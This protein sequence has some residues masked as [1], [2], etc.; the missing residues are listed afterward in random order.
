MPKWSREIHK[1]MKTIEYNKLIRDKIPE[2]IEKQG[3]TCV[4]SR[5]NDE[6]YAQ[7]LAEKLTE[8]MQE[9]L[10]EFDAEKDEEAVKELADLVEVVYAILDL[11]GVDK[12]DFEKIRQAKTLQ[13]GAFKNKLLLLQVTQE[14]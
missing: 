5:L 2:I 14:E 6:E 11:I 3:K 10:R 12:N 13:N 7:K 1:K 8:E 9:F 4:V